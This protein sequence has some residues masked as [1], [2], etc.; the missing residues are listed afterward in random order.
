VSEAL[1][2]LLQRLSPAER[3][4]FVLHDVFQL[5][6]D[7]VAEILGKSSA[8]CRQLAKRARAK[9]VSGPHTAKREM[10]DHEL[11]KISQTFLAACANGD[12][13]AL[14]AV[15]HDEVWGVADF[16]AGDPPQLRPRRSSQQIQ[17]GADRIARSLLRFFGGNITLVSA[18]AASGLAFLAFLRQRPY[19]TITA[20][21]DDGLLTSMHVVVNQDELRA[22]TSPTSRAGE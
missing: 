22:D 12:L 11:R 13:Q 10:T 15:L 6:F 19:A 14:T 18:P 3:V 4:S 16:T 7:Q 9:V 17:R 2:I 1:L 21:V 8:T 5:P 20:S